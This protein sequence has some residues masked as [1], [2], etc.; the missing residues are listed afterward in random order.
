[1]TTK[2]VGENSESYEELF[3]KY[4]QHNADALGSLG[5]PKEQNL[6]FTLQKDG[7]LIDL[8]VLTYKLEDR[9][10]NPDLVRIK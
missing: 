5:Q 7:E 3:K 10:Y 2:Q 4:L 1:M 9:D 8:N 6:G